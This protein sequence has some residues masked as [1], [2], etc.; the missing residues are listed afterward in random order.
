M[1]MDSMT[2]N[3]WNSRGQDA[4][5]QNDYA[6]AIEC[7][8]KA[9]EMEP[10]WSVPHYNLGLT[11]KFC[12]NWQECRE[13]NWKAHQ[14]DP[15]DEAAIWNLAISSVA[16]GDWESAR[17]AFTGIGLE[18]PDE[19]GPWTFNFG[20]TPIRV[21]PEEN[22]EVVWARRLDPVRASL[23]NVPFADCGRRYGDIV[24][25]DGAPNGYRLLGDRE[26]PVFDELKLLEVSPLHTFEVILE[27]T[28]SVESLVALMEEHELQAENWSKSVRFL[29]RA[30]SEGRPHESHDHDLEEPPDDLIRLGVAATDQALI[31]EVVGRWKAGSVKRLE[32][33]L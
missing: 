23:I 4:L 5:D 1:H 27:S 10:E 11:H 15:E 8:G 2:A 28:E 3:A 19:P 18:V 12:K 26:V 17:T 14:L 32:R 9:I 7:F 30:C 20:I 13:H 29:C 22:P 33:V 25:H 24:L 6:E 16:V 31:E 21:N